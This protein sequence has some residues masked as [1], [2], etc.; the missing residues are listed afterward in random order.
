LDAKSKQ[1]TFAMSSIQRRAFERKRCYRSARFIYN[2]GRCSLDSV[3][4]NISSKGALVQGADFRDVPEN[5]EL[6]IPSVQGLSNRRRARRVWAAGE[7]MG[8]A[9]LD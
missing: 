3:L 8:V 9:F 2:H 1:E 6:F 4:R 7:A 5:F